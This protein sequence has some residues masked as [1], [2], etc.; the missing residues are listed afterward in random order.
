MILHK[1]QL[2]ALLT[3]HNIHTSSLDILWEVDENVVYG[4]I[5]DGNNAIETWRLLY[6]IISRTRHYPVLLGSKEQANC[7]IDCNFPKLAK[8]SN[9]TL[10]VN[11][12]INIGNSLNSEQWL[13]KVEAERREEWDFFYPEEDEAEKAIEYYIFPRV[14][15]SIHQEVLIQEPYQEVVLALV[16]TSLN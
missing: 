8:Y 1:S 5:V 12:I 14:Q 15:Y 3:Q 9:Q 16:P 13:I 2:N 6:E 4:I 11:Q 10:T 7:Y